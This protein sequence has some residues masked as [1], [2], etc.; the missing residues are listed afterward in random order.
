M[1]E[2][3]QHAAGRFELVVA[4]GEGTE[5]ERAT[6]AAHFGIGQA[7]VNFADAGDDECAGAHRAGLFGDVEG[8][9]VEPPVAEGVGRLRDGE[10][11]GVC[12]RVVGRARLV[13]RGGDDAAAVLDHGTDR[14]FVFFPRLNGL[15]VGVRHVV[16]GVAPE[17]GRVA[18]F[19]RAIH[20]RSN[21]DSIIKS[22]GSFRVR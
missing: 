15:V 2:I 5:I 19:K 20:F 1:V 9:F 6:H 10:D 22:M 8:A 4:P 17:R 12:G 11:L 7:V 16:V 3:F 21:S 13:V 14:H 18:F